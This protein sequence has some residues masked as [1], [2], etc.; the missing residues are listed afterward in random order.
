M[1]YSTEI[2]PILGIIL[3]F[4]LLIPS[5]FKWFHL[6]IATSLILAGLI[7]GPGGL[8]YV[9]P[10]ETLKMFAFVGANFLMLLAGFESPAFRSEIVNK[11]GFVLIFFSSLL[12][13]TI[14]LA[15][16]RYFDYS[17]PTS[18]FVAAMFLTS[19]I[20]ITFSTLDQMNLYNV[21]I[22]KTIKS[23]VASQD[24]TGA[25]ISFVILKKH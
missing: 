20:L 19:S 6:P 1:Q 14:G 17:W 11:K 12:P 4:G 25:L 2:L 23:L 24:L 7:A 3:F 10:N 5:L 15:L 8:N 16:T 21:R 22:E 13:A 18:L 9:P